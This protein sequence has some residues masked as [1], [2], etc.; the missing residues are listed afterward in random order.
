[1]FLRAPHL[2]RNLRTLALCAAAFCMI[3]PADWTASAQP[4]RGGTVVVAMQ[5]EPPTLTSAF[6]PAGFAEVVSTKV[7]EGL[8]TYDFDLTPLPALAESWS[9]SDDGLVYTFNLRR[10]VRWHDGEPFTSA[11]VA[12]SL[13]EVWIKLHPR[14]SA[15]FANVTDVSTPD[16]HTLVFKVSEPSPAIMKALASY[17]SQILPRHIYEGTDITSNPA[18][19]APIGTGPFK[20][21]EWQRGNFTRYERN[22]DYWD[23]GKPYVDELIFRYIADAGARAAAMET[24]E[25]QLATFNP[26]PL[27][28]VERLAG[29]GFLNVETK[30]YE[31]LSP[32]FLIE[33]NQRGE[34]LGNRDVRR[35]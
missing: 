22:E 26:V 13:K 33:L 6:N 34:Y 32:I 29:T 10:G 21:V 9:L 1:M 28:D 24:G 11:D 3:T 15:I 14:G 20:F 2:P 7:L 12:F 5:S 25:A 18:N 23:T 19:N 4:V 31:Y 8:L 27:N 35:A 17:G 30:G 16:D